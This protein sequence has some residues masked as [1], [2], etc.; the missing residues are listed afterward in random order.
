V[1]GLHVQCPEAIFGQYAN[2]K[3]HAL[4]VVPLPRNSGLV[5][6]GAGGSAVS[7]ESLTMKVE[8]RCAVQCHSPR[9]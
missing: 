9:L 3:A 1:S 2:V 7:R 6:R 5:A 8:A 4:L